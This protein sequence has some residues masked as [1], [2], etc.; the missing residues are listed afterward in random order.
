M[1]GL[2]NDSII[3]YSI[4]RSQPC[5]I[6]HSQHTNVHFSN[7]IAPE[8]LFKNN[9]LDPRAFKAFK[10]NILLYIKDLNEKRVGLCAYNQVNYFL[11]K[12]DITYNEPYSAMCAMREIREALVRNELPDLNSIKQLN[13]AFA[14]L[15]KK[16]SAE[17]RSLIGDK[18]ISAF[19]RF[20]KALTYSFESK[21]ALT[22]RIKDKKNK[23][24]A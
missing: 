5:T 8:R 15:K 9:E 3:A 7:P 24:A 6:N 19:L 21:K 14:N 18:I 16:L 4:T 13:N 10:K 23:I 22:S 20:R 2:N 11:N 12:I 17:K 1:G